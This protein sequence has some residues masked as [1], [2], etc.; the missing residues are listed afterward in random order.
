MTCEAVECAV[1]KGAKTIGVNAEDASRSDL[2]Y[3]IKLAKEVKKCGAY[4][5]RYCDTLGYEDPQTTY[6]RI[7]KLAKRNTNAN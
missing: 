7:Y 1:S 4:R 2:D 5:F 3:L 6:D